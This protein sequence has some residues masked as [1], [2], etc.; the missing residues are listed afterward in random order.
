[1]WEILTVL[2]RIARGESQAAVA[3]TTG[4][5]PKTIRR[6]VRAA[7]SLG[8]EPGTDPTT[9]ALA[10]KVFLRH[11]P[12]GARGPGRVEEDLLPHLEPTMSQP[13]GRG[14]TPP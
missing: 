14:I 1:M 10:A 4:H 6:Y 9:E 7:E 13:P 12:A 3:R 8:W 11:R 5:V 2:E